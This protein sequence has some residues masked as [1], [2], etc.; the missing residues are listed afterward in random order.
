VDNNHRG[1]LAPSFGRRRLAEGDAL[2]SC[3]A[4][5]FNARPNFTPGLRQVLG[6]MS[7]FD[8]NKRLEIFYP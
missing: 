5:F 8:R 3:T 4:G 7:V 6:K 1:R 2:K